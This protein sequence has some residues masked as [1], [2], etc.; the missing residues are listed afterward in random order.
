MNGAV[1]HE[2]KALVIGCGIAG[3]AVALFLKRAGF[4]PFIYEA[5]KKS[6]EYEGLFFNLASNGLRVLQELGIDGPVMEEGIAMRAMH[7]LNG[8]GRVLGVIGDESGPVRGYTVKRGFLHKVLRDEALRQGIPIVYDKRL[9]EIENNSVYAVTA[10]FEDGTSETGKLLIGCDGIHSKVRSIVLPDAPK[11]SYTG[12]LSYGGFSPKKSGTGKS[13][14]QTMIFGRR[15]FFGYVESDKETFWFGNMN[16]SGSPTRKELQ[17]IPQS[18]WRSRIEQLHEQDVEPVPQLVQSTPGAF[19][20]YPI[21]DI[22]KQPVWHQ[23]SVVLIGDAVHAT[24]PSA[25]QGASLAL[26][27]AMV[28]AK[29]LRD[30]PHSPQAFASFQQLR[31]ERVERIVQYSRRIGQ[32]KHAT[33][34]VQ[35]FFRDLM[36]PLFLKSAKK[37]S[38]T[39]LYDYRIDWEKSTRG[40]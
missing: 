33:N 34:P 6:D 27:D 19:G 21:Y 38:H 2:K 18:E 4:E 31:K 15:A 8:K 3:P 16:L 32:R 10:H 17:Q 24:S 5:D 20:V 39:W 37:Q 1:N 9:K 23:G 22:P 12:L 14:L 30:N 25:G 35:V 36:L 7:M 11:P 29:C 28:L 40:M 26:E 13:E